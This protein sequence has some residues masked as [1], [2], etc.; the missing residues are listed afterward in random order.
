MNLLEN[1]RGCVLQD[2]VSQQQTS[3]LASDLAGA[4]A[5]FQDPIEIC[6]LE[7]APGN[8]NKR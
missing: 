7:P 4:N 1:V 2:L 6:S 3:R 8:V 5:A